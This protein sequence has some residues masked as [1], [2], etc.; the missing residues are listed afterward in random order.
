MVKTKSIKSSPTIN[1]H[2]RPDHC[3]NVSKNH[4]IFARN[5]KFNILKWNKINVYRD[6]ITKENN[7]QNSFEVLTRK[8]RVDFKNIICS[9]NLNCQSVRTQHLFHVINLTINN[10]R[11]H[12]L[13]L[14]YLFFLFHHVF[15]L[16]LSYFHCYSSCFL[17]KSLVVFSLCCVPLNSCTITA[18]KTSL[19][20]S[21]RHHQNRVTWQK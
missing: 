9:I 8:S 3:K 20:T 1:M 2:V 7:L 16:F 19:Q 13:W 21:I 6:C 15:C 14:W 10:L 4:R 11:E 5:N 12:T 17:L 18:N